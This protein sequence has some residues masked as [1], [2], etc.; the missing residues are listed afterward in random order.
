MGEGKLSPGRAVNPAA[1]ARVGC[2][3]ID[4]VALAE[5]GGYQ[6]V[7][8]LAAVEPVCTLSVEQSVAHSQTPKM[9]GARIAEGAVDK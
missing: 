1:I 7:A 3:S 2:A 4:L 9:V 8:V 5:A 6:Q